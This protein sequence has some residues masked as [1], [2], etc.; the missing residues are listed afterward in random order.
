MPRSQDLAIFVQ[1]TDRQQ[2]K[3]ITLPLAHVHGVIIV[4]AYNQCLTQHMYVY[5]RSSLHLLLSSVI[6]IRFQV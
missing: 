1:T 5:V 4:H 3:L 2:T 6:I